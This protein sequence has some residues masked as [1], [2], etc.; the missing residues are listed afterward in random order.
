MALG[1]LSQMKYASLGQKALNV[2]IDTI[3]ENMSFDVN[4]KLPSLEKVDATTPILENVVLSKINQWL[5][6]K[7]L[8]GKYRVHDTHSAST[9]L[10][11]DLKP[12][13][14][15]STQD[16]MQADE[17][18]G[19][20]GAIF[21]IDTIALNQ[22][23]DTNECVGQAAA[24]CIRL[25]E[26]SAPRRRCYAN[27]CITNLQQATI[28]QVSRTDIDGQYTFRKA[29]ASNALVFAYL[30]A[31][32]VASHGVNG[33]QSSFKLGDRTITP[34]HYLGS[35]SSA[36]VY[37]T[38]D[39]HTIKF[40][41]PSE[42][43]HLK[44]I[45]RDVLIKLNENKPPNILLQ[46]VLAEDDE[47]IW[48]FLLLKPVGRPVCPLVNRSFKLELSFHEILRTLHYAHQCGVLHNDI[49]PENLIILDD[50]KYLLIDWTASW[51]IGTGTGTGIGKMEEQ[52]EY[53]GCVS[54]AAD[55]ILNM[56]ADKPLQDS[57]STSTYEVIAS[58][59]T[60][61]IAA[62]RTFTVLAYR[63]YSDELDRLATLRGALDF[64]GIV[65]WWDKHLSP[66]AKDF[67]VKLCEMW[68]NNTDLD[69]IYDTV[70]TY[71]TASYPYQL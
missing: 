58:P 55:S 24:Y 12:D 65:E 20:F 26:L 45:E 47:L 7:L 8:C 36:E 63:I 35:G 44:A 38:T 59:V 62:L 30:F 33:Q 1:S 60:D 64:I 19:E 10:G 57:L 27:C 34:L 14:I 5:C 71:I 25:L 61:L 52:R 11:S 49:R 6:D 17:L 40:F 54:Y 43:T 21:F 3:F 41:V 16:I 4:E 29:S 48:S 15:V 51:D 32:D 67:E 23:T 53:Y 2:K 50:G 68:D 37:S 46:N 28:V 56:L 31:I 70:Y 22:K 13:F 39:N 42:T 69:T 18:Y 9:F 66:S